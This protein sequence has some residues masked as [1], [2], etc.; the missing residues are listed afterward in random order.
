VTSGQTSASRVDSVPDVSVVIP[1]LNA[2]HTLGVQ[3]AALGRQRTDRSFEVLV[4]DNGSTD[5][6]AQVVASFG[7]TVPGLRL[8]DASRRTGSNVARNCGA[9]AARGDLVLLCDADDEVADDWLERLASG[10]ETAG[11]VGGRLE[12]VK[13]NADYIAAWGAPWG[14]PGITTQLG[15]L[16]R[17]LGAN[18]GF[19]RSV[20]EELGG[21]DE[22]YVRGGTET[23]FFW[24]LQLA[25]H[26]LVDVPE[27]IVHYRLRPSFRKSVR[28]MYVWG[29]Q[30][31][32]LYRDF[33]TSGMEW[34]PRETAWALLWLVRLVP[35]AVRTRASRVDLARQVAYRAGRV[36]GSWHY[37]VLYL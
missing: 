20:W 27:A 1:S 11:G 23:E 33:R 16:P 32:M 9:A 7:G 2:G 31:A 15:F 4:A 34:A 35:R 37:R 14:Q 5:D 36:V 18:A 6:T 24:R 3:L 13:L 12:R 28:Q 26:P 29:R 19:R 25:G 22:D 21:F 17:P 30:H 8:V 10:L